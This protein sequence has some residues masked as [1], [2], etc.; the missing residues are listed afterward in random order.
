MKTGRCPVCHTDLHLDALLEDDAGRELTA[1]VINLPHGVGRHLVA[2][3]GLFR[4]QKSNLSNS[5][6]LKLC[7]EV[8]ALYQP[9]RAL[10][11]ALSET[12]ARIH[13]KRAQGDRA[14]LA[15][16]SYLASVY[17]TSSE[18][19]ARTSSVAEREKEQRS[20]SDSPDAYFL[21]ML[22]MKVDITK[23]NGGRE[24]LEDNP[25]EQK[26]GTWHKKI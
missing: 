9:S 2:Y 14:P 20:G 22:N 5:R 26:G 25:V 1:K 13:A 7:D 21:Q 6:A 24:W 12:V 19:F 4:P 10:A 3:V 16:H 15:N 8:L 23:L 18:Q 11:H 17:K